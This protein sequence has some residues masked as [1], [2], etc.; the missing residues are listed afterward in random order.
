MSKLSVI[1]I[2]SLTTAISAAV[3]LVTPK[4]ANA[5]PNWEYRN[6]VF[7]E[8]KYVRACNQGWGSY[9]KVSSEAGS[10]D[11]QDKARVIDVSFKVYSSQ[12]MK[13]QWTSYT[14]NA[15]WRTINLNPMR[16][17]ESGDRRWYTR[18][19][20]YPV[21][22]FNPDREVKISQQVRRRSPGMEY[23]VIDLGGVVNMGKIPFNQCRVFD[24]GRFTDE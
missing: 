3:S 22:F 11:R 21:T 10:G 12:V 9:I 14:N 18:E 19:A 7:G 13:T 15:N 23:S 20:S 1:A 4:A 17:T 8:I 16:N 6:G 2:L 5:S 24:D